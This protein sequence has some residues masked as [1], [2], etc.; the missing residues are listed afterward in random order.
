MRSPLA[1]MLLLSTAVHLALAGLIQP[2]PG[3]ST[4]VVSSISARIVEPLPASAEPPL[5]EASLAEIEA[6]ALPDPIS[7]PAEALPAVPVEPA[8]R[9]PE[10]VNAAEPP[11]PAPPV[12]A[13][14]TEDLNPSR[15]PA[16]KTENLLPSVPVMLDTTWYSAR[17]LDVQPKAEYSIE[18]D[19]P[20]DARRD[21][22]RGNVTLLIRV[23][24]LGEVKQVTVESGNPPGVFDESA[25]LAFEQARFIPA[26]LNGQAVR[27]EIRIRVTYTL[28]DE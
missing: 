20:E 19:Y 17:Q 14:T 1:R 27:A 2:R 11:A 28:N 3:S 23:D 21:G 22:T 7:L 9:P 24:E 13:V 12:R 4:P 25:K 8:A 26:R 6:M 5:A 18:P 16:R 15:L 10:R